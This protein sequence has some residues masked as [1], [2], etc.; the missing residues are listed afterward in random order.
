MTK[1]REFIKKSLM[2][3]AGIAMAFLNSFPEWAKMAPAGFKHK[4]L[5]LPATF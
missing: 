1:R 3:T 5:S 4:Q 2:G